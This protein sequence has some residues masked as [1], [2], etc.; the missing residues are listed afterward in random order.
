MRVLAAQAGRPSWL[1]VPSLALRLAL[2]E[3]GPALVPGQ[4]IMPRAA[5]SG[6][7]EFSQPTLEGALSDLLA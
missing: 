6:G 1:P 5:L 4:R 7:Y 2:G 3:L